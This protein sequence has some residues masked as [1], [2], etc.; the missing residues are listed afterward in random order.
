MQMTIYI[1]LYNIWMLITSI[2][3]RLLKFVPFM[4][5]RVVT[6][7]NYETFKLPLGSHGGGIELGYQIKWSS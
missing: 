4:T 5:T 2:L 3:A 7:T 1:K 6:T